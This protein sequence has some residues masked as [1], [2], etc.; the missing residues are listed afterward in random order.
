M[1]FRSEMPVRIYATGGSDNTDPEYALKGAITNAIGNAASKIG[2]Q[3]S[4]FM[5]KRS[6]HNVG[7][8]KTQAPSAKKLTKEEAAAAH[9]MTSGPGLGKPAW[10]LSDGQTAFYLKEGYKPADAAAETD[11][12]ACKVVRD[13]RN[14]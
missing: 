11:V 13:A 7:K 6:H 2:F 10:M 9:V 14:S 5:G 3:E 1:L 8:A 4:V 12:R